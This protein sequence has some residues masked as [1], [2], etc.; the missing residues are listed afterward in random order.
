M[1]PQ[2]MLIYWNSVIHR[3][4][5]INASDQIDE[6]LIVP[7]HSTVRLDSAQFGSTPSIY[8]RNLSATRRTISQFLRPCD[9]ISYVI[10]MRKSRSD[11]PYQIATRS[12]GAIHRYRVLSTIISPH[13]SV[14]TITRYN[15]DRRGTKNTELYP[16]AIL[17]KDIEALPHKIKASSGAGYGEGCPI[18][19]RLGGRR[20]HR[21]LYQRGSERNPVGNAFWHILK[22]TER[23]FLYLYACLLYT[24]PSPRD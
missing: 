13:I 11:A 4:R 5:V 18:P 14:R 2:M 17:E 6:W 12:I 10:T 7:H 9:R 24:S 3:R 21:K 22:A 1:K 15:A 19:S 23:S 8:V 20:E 16:G